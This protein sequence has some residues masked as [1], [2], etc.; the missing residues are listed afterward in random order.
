MEILFSVITPSRGLRP[1]ALQAAGRSLEAAVAGAGLTPGQVEWLV[2]FDGI[3][4]ERPQ[5]D[6]PCR[7]VDFPAW[8]DFG[9]RIRDR[10]LRL[11]RGGHVLFLDD[12][13]AYLPGA[14]AVFLP[15]LEAEMLIGRVDTSRAFPVAVLPVP[16]EPAERTIR[17]GNVDPL[18]LCLSRELVVRRCGGWASE[19]GYESDFCN[20]RRYHHRARSVL[21]LDALVGIYDAGA[22]L[23]PQ[24]QNPRQQRTPPCRP[25][26]S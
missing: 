22:G 19:G 5:T 26:T 2:G 11:A 16:G 7:C 21:V 8:G 23:D 14:L 1:R 10:L 17:Q 20:I 15:H 9:N 3:K 24:G 25:S 18:C 12:D 4:G 6:L 13:N